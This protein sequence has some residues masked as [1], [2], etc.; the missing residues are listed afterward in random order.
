M[1]D[2]KIEIG[3]PDEVC[4]Q[5]AQCYEGECRAMSMPHSE[6]EREARTTCTGMECDPPRLKQI[7]MMRHGLRYNTAEP[8]F[9]PAK[10]E[11]LFRRKIDEARK[12]SYCDYSFIIKD[13]MNFNWLLTEFYNDATT[14]D[15]K[16]ERLRLTTK[17][18]DEFAAAVEQKLKIRCGCKP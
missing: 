13:T 8:I 9:D 18:A 11:E 1:I 7:R 4:A 6:K 3:T 5:C 16:T 12:S 2:H 17:L 14:L 10:A 15:E